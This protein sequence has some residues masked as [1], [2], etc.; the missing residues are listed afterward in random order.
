[1]H[2]GLRHFAT[3]LILTTLSLGSTQAL[4]HKQ[5][6]YGGW[7]WSGNIEHI[8]IDP[9]VAHRRDVQIG[10]SATALGIGAEYFTAN[11]GPSFSLGLSYILYNDN[12]EFYQYV[13]DDW[14][15]RS[16][17]QSDANALMA[18][19]EIGQKI[20]FGWDQLNFFT[21]RAGVNGIFASER[22]IA[23]CSNCYAEDLDING[24]FY[25]VLGVGHSFN[26]MDIELQFQQYFS[27]DLDNSL[28]LK[29]S[30]R[31]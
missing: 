17:E 31:F 26:R 21:A 9:D 25:G 10:E 13:H 14:N 19:A 22:A 27:G 7:S 6:S 20:P 2:T 3:A 30:S 18:S 8:N 5:A 11:E 29:I 12:N 1:M 24:G 28:R 23:N 16:Y 15:G 4:A